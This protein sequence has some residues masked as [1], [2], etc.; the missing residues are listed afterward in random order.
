MTSKVFVSYWP[1][2]GSLWIVGYL[3][4]YGSFGFPLRSNILQIEWR[5]L[6]VKIIFISHPP[7]PYIFLFSSSFSLSLTTSSFL[8]AVLSSIREAGVLLWPESC[9]SLS[10]SP[11]LKVCIVQESR[12][13]HNGPF[14]G[15]GQIFLGH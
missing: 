6:E 14:P 13:I 2:L 10:Q 8:L 4:A 12:A 9:F 15:K 7:S 1:N 11:K 3:R 5:N